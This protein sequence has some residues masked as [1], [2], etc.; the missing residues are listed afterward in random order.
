MRSWAGTILWLFC[1]SHTLLGGCAELPTSSPT[2]PSSEAETRTLISDSA[3][4]T[5][6]GNIDSHPESPGIPPAANSTPPGNLGT[7]SD[8]T[9]HF[10]KEAST[11]GPTVSLKD[12]SRNDTVTNEA[13][14]RELPIDKNLV[15]VLLLVIAMMVLISLIVL[16]FKCRNYRKQKREAKNS[17]SDQAITD[18]DQVTLISIRTTDTDAGEVSYGKN[19]AVEN[20]KVE[21]LS[22]A[23]VHIQQSP[24]LN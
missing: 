20:G 7:D 19:D 10:A 18:K 12:E 4:T 1:F 15:L 9:T 11:D 6:G 22:Q 23:Q 16:R 13:P 24:S 14:D 2:R 8:S 21:D 3:A 17:T 5:H